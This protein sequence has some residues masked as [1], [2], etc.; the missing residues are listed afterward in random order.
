MASDINRASNTF[1]P[2]KKTIANLQKKAG[3]PIDAGRELR[4][5]D[6]TGQDCA[7][8]PSRTN[9]GPE[10]QARNILC[11]NCSVGKVPFATPKR[12]FLNTTA[13]SCLQMKRLGNAF[14]V[15][16]TWDL[17]KAY[18]KYKKH[19]RHRWGNCPR[20]SSARVTKRFVL[21]DTTCL[22]FVACCVAVNIT[23]C[24]SLPFFLGISVTPPSHPT[25]KR[26]TQIVCA[27]ETEAIK[28][29]AFGGER[30]GVLVF[31][32]DTRQ[33]QARARQEKHPLER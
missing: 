25:E 9:N 16:G 31:D 21:A 33:A 19:H 22:H 1:A 8:K 3:I 17:L 6:L 5:K 15:H 27:D 23:R 10:K 18:P 7:N 29:K 24:T 26:T 20:S 12:F 11:R 4:A 2:T 28:P 13:V 32:E 14:L 30:A